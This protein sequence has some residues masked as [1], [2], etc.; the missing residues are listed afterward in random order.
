[1]WYKFPEEIFWESFSYVTDAPGKGLCLTPALDMDTGK[2][3]KAFFGI[4]CDWEKD[5]ARN[6]LK[7]HK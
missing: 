2:K 5:C 7:A 4:L 3:N 1:M 6:K